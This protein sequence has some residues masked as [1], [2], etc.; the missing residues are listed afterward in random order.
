M[1]EALRIVERVLCHDHLIH[2]LLAAIDEAHLLDVVG[3]SI[4]R[5]DAIAQHAGEQLIEEN[6][7]GMSVVIARRPTSDE[8]GTLRPTTWSLNI[9]AGCKPACK[10]QPYSINE[11]RHHTKVHTYKVCVPAC[12][13]IETP[14]PKKLPNKGMEPTP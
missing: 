7:G 13:E 12:V 6:F 4:L 9:Y 8:E 3:L 2:K 1:T 10:C 5:R 14:E 11:C